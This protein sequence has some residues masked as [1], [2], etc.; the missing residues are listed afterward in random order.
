MSRLFSLRTVAFESRPPMRRLAVISDIHGNLHAL[1]AVLREIRRLGIR[2]IVC[3]GD[4]VGY[5]PHPGVC[6]DLV[7]EHCRLTIR[8]NHEDAVVEPEEAAAFNPAAREAIEWTRA[9]LT[10]GQRD[11]IRLLP[12]VAT[13]GRDVLCVHDSPACGTVN[14]LHTPL[15]AAEAFR[16]LEQSICLFGHTHVPVVFEAPALVTEPDAQSIVTY[17]MRHDA[18]MNFLKGRRYLV[19]P[20]SVGQPR[21]NDP[22]ASF[23]LLDLAAGS[24]S[25]QRLAYD[26]DAARLASRRAGLPARLGERLA[27]G[28]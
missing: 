21:D 9:A 27:I 13:I 12:H 25:V 5:G 18:T 24:F 28:A 6:L 2:D 4:V 23:G 17:A 10:P 16:G 7:L 14:Y 3:L 15:A 22:R 19:N 8:G 20:G 1:L 26:I 11:M